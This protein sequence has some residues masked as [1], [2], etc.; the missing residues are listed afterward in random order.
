MAYGEIYYCQFEE[1]TGKTVRVSIQEDG[2]TGINSEITMDGNEP[3]TIESNDYDKVRSKTAVIRLN[4]TFTDRFLFAKMVQ[5]DYTKYKLIITYDSNTV[6]IG[7]MLQ[8]TYNQRIIYKDDIILTFSSGIGNLQYM[9]PDILTDSGNEYRTIM[10]YLISVMD[11]L[12]YDYKIYINSTLYEDS[13]TSS[14]KADNPFKAALLN[15]YLFYGNDGKWD[16]ALLIL[17]KILGGMNAYA[18]IKGDTLYVQRLNDMKTT[19]KT[20][21]TYDSA[22]AAYSNVAETFSLKS[23][24]TTVSEIGVNYSVEPALKLYKLYLKSANYNNLVNNDFSRLVACSP[25]AGD[26]ENNLYQWTYNDDYINM[27]DTNYNS[28]FIDSGLK[29]YNDSGKTITEYG[30]NGWLNY[31]GMITNVNDDIIFSIAFKCFSPIYVTEPLLTIKYKML[32][33]SPGSGWGFSVDQDGVIQSDVNHYRE[34]KITNTGDT[35]IYENKVND[36]LDIS[37]QLNSLGLTGD[38][39]FLFEVYPPVLS[40]LDGSGANAERSV[41]GDFFLKIGDKINNYLEADLN[42]VAFTEKEE[43]I[44]IF[45]IGMINYFNQPVRLD[46]GNYA[47]TALWSDWLWSAKTLQQHYILNKSNQYQSPVPSFDITIQDSSQEIDMLDMFE[48]NQLQDELS[49]NMTF[50]ITKY[51]WNVKKHT[52]KLKLTKWL[53]WAGLGL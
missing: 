22:T 49:N 41:Y 14:E 9:Y 11:L 42:N 23:Y 46:S 34:I 1:F 2:Y 35:D 30:N 19:S 36:T 12:G 27:E 6:F 8:T 43:T 25:A 48:T 52:Y 29:Y 31:N 38:I 10:E 53:A 17:N 50:W 40:A 7:Y 39:E 32:F 26:P 45:D 37:G 3:I 51:K 47:H 13:M 18:H 33:R 5:E 24:E 15:R 21:W 28:G 44:Y 16:N 20:W 4:N